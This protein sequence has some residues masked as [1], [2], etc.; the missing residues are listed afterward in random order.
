MINR[1]LDLIEVVKF[2]KEIKIISQ[3]SNLPIAE[4]LEAKSQ[5]QQTRK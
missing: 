4:F 3:K 5:R 1:L 2:N